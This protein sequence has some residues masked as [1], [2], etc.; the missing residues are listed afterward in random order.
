MRLAPGATFSGNFV[1]PV[2][3]GATHDH[4]ADR[5]ADADAAGA[6]SA[7]DAGDG[8]AVREDR[9]AQHRRGAADRAAARTTG[10]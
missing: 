6:E 1:L 10:G 9:V 5:L 2:F 7:G 4:G 3:A 8:G